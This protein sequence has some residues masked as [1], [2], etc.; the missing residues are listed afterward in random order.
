MALLSA[1]DARRGLARNARAGWAGLGETGIRI[2]PEDAK[3]VVAT[4]VDFR[5]SYCRSLAPVLDSVLAEF[6]GDI[7][8]EIH[9][10]PLPSHELAA[11]GKCRARE[12]GAH[13]ARGL[14]SPL[15][16]RSRFRSRS[17]SSTAVNVNESVEWNPEVYL[18]DYYSAVEPDEQGTLKFLVREFRRSRAGVVLLWRGQW[19]RRA[20]RLVTLYDQHREP[21]A[22]VELSGS[23]ATRTARDCGGRNQRA[24][25][26]TTWS[27]RA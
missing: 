5:C 25:A 27:I 21:G 9:H 14:T 3:M 17:L 19:D 18:R 6:K 1:A 12:S 26:R 24:A 16:S 22:A 2:G 11:C 23:C 4:F 13:Q 10:F 8:I 20:G 7:A 15:R